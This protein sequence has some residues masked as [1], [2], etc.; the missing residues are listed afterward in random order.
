MPGLVRVLFFLADLIFLNLAI[1]ASYAI[2]ISHS[3]SVNELYLVI[4][5][6]LAWL[7]LVLIS[8]P[9]GINK[10]WTLSKIIKSQFVFL[11]IHILVVTS[12]I[13]FFRKSYSF[14]QIATTYLIFVP[15][16]ILWKLATFYIRKINAHVDTRKYLVIGRNSLAFDLRKYFLLNPE[17]GFRFV[18]YIDFEDR[19]IEVAREF[20]E[21]NEVHQIFCC[22][23]NVTEK[24][25]ARLVNFGLD[26]L[27]QVKIVTEGG[28]KTRTLKLDERSAPPT[29][30]MAVIPL[31]ESRHQFTKRV[32]D[33]IFSFLFTVLVLSWL[34]PMIAILIKIESKGPIFFVQKRNGQ[35]NTPFGCI[36]FRTMVVNQESDTKQATKNDSRITRVG[37]FLRKS[38]IDE[39][40]QFIN[41]LIG[42]MS[43][44]GPRPHPIKL[45]EEF[46]TKITNIIAR[47]YVKPGITG[48]AQCMGYRG[49]TKDLADMENRVRLDRYY[50]ENWTFWLD[51]KIVFLTVVSLLRGS[52]KAY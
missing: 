6:S 14:A 31:D 19:F 21:L 37:K 17:E 2:W 30:E 8:D 51:I 35:R 43:I 13:I 16:F 45:N 11:L 48:L 50:I 25:I 18:G 52:E 42:Q 20:C 27:I 28:V 26:S 23:P 29:F 47:H 40:P 1:Y 36:K 9:Y 10:N 41:V 3:D 22:A 34:V 46:A 4:Y 33:L 39:F 5:S 24:E 15:V 7:F 49:E 32:F 38:S 12:L 44:I